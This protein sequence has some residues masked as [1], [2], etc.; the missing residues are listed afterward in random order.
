M[1]ALVAYSRAGVGLRAALIG[2]VAVF[3]GQA[4]SIRP[5]MSIGPRFTIGTRGL[6]GNMS[7]GRAAY[8]GSA[9]LPKAPGTATKSAN[10]QERQGTERISPEWC[11][12]GC[13]F[14]LWY[15]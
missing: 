8:V 15:A 12:N 2:A 10:V 5:S 14:K 7:M 4:F 6:F 1:R 13:R 11:R 3:R 9:E